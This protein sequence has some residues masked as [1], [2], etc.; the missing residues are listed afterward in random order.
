MPYVIPATQK[1]EAEDSS[2]RPGWTTEGFKGR[3]RI[4]KTKRGGWRD[5]LQLRSLAFY[6]GSKFGAQ[7]PN[8]AHL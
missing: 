4:Y 2:A 5:D 3:L 7:H 6:R 1:A 8:G